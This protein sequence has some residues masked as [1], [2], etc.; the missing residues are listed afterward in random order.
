MQTCAS[1]S[2]I[3]CSKRESSVFSPV[4]TL[5]LPAV[6]NSAAATA[7]IP[8]TTR[9]PPITPCPNRITAKP[10][11]DKRM[12]K[13]NSIFFLLPASSCSR[14]HLAS[15]CACMDCRVFLCISFACRRL[16][17]SLRFVQAFFTLSISASC[18]I[19]SAKYPE[20]SSNRLL[21]SPDRAFFLVALSRLS[22]S[23]ASA[24]FSSNCALSAM[25]KLSLH[26]A[27]SSSVRQ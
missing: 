14:K 13:S 10:P 1:S 26:C 6:N 9:T 27:C 17:P 15:S 20:S 23:C 22:S 5:D 11:S 7:A 18:G 16:F 8:S 19:P 25:G 12:P 21:S 2:S 3:S 4:W 24:Y